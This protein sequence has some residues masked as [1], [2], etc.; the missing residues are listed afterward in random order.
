MSSNLLVK[1]FKHVSMLRSVKNPDKILAPNKISTFCS[2]Y[3][4]YIIL[5][6]TVIICH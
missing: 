2:T 5:I 1:L 4:A 6:I 3:N